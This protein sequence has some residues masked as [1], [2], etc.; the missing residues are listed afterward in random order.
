MPWTT[1]ACQVTARNTASQGQQD[2]EWNQPG[3]PTCFRDA[4]EITGK[5]RKQGCPEEKWGCREEGTVSGH[6]ASGREEVGESC[7]GRGAHQPEGSSVSYAKTK[8]RH[9][10][11][12]SR[13]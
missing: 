4:E 13:C 7:P 6:E 1:G 11:L 10:D 2:R 12:G 5:L 3:E 8:L 9:A